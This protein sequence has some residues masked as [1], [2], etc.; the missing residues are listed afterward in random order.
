MTTLGQVSRR[1]FL[2]R[3]GALAAGSFAIPH[4][5]PRGVL[6]APGEPGANDRIILGFIGAGGRA[7]QLMDQVPP[8]GQIVAVADCYLPRAKE[9]AHSR[10]DKWDV[11]QDYRKILD[12]KDIDAVVIPTHD[13]ARVFVCI[14]ACQ[15]GKDVYAEKPLTV[16]IG[17]G[18]AL[19][20]AVRKHERVFQVGSQ[21]RSM[22]VNR[23]ACELVRTGGIG[24]VRV[25]QVVN[26]T[27]PG[28]YTGLPEEPVPEGLDW[29]LWCNQTDLRPYNKGIQFGWMGFRDYSGGEMTNWGAHG[30]DQVQWALD[31]SLTGPVE[32][33]PVG[34]GPN[35][36]VSMRYADGTLV[37]FELPSDGPVGGA[38]FVGEKAKIEINRNK[39]TT[40]PPDLVKDPPKPESAEVWE[41]PGWTAKLHIKNWLDC[42][43]TRAKPNADVEIGHRS[44]S[45]CHLANIAREIGR[46][47]RWDPDK[48]TFPGDAEANGY[49]NRPRRKGYELPEVG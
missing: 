20:N 46:K 24:K 26:Y 28:R 8:P 9:S 21:Q 34:E 42:I 47:L 2:T 39:F 10:G 11:Y 18:R 16:T 32:V 13:H 22:E 44:I 25:V 19:V 5:I 48:E 14:R 30:V 3:A 29:D 1:R 33:W 37:R 38:I 6:A 49:V 43:P 17:E 36:K 41:G 12:R 7:N 4:L 27:G 45:M 35:G 40:N 15:A 23:F 31:K